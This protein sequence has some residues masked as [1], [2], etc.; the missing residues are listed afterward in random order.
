MLSRPSTLNRPHPPVR[1][2]P[3]SFPD[4]RLWTRSSTF[5]GHIILS[6][7]LTFRSFTAELS[8]IAAVFTPGD[9]MRAPQF[10]RI[11]T[12]HRAANRPLASPFIP[13]ISFVWGAHFEA[14]YDRSLSLRPSG[15]FAVLADQTKSGSAFGLRRLLTSQLAGHGSLRDQWDVLRRQTEI[16]ADGTFTR[17]FN[18]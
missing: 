14:S 11:S 3:R 6:V 10:F 2:T 8:R 13:Q 18:S 15:S 17:K 4:G 5:K 16:C 7:L 12:G 9:Q 1:R